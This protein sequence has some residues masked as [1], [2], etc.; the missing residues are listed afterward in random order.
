MGHQVTGLTVFIGIRLPVLEENGMN[1]AEPSGAYE[2]LC[3]L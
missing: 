3:V 1:I 2:P